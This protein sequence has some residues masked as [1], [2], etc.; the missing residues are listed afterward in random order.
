VS[1]VQPL[2]RLGLL[3][4]VHAE[5]EA[6]KVAIGGLEERGVDALLCAGDIADGMGDIN[7]ACT[8]LEEH[9]V[10]CVAGNHDRW[11]LSDELRDE[12]CATSMKRVLPRARHYLDSLPTTRKLVTP[13][14]ALLLCHGIGDDDLACVKPDHLRHD[15]ERNDAL[16]RVLQGP[17]YDF[18]VNGHTHRAMLRRVRHLTIINAGTLHRNDERR[19][20]LLDLEAR[21]VTFFE[22][23]PGGLVEIESIPLPEVDEWSRV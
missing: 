2:V 17:R 13:H 7:R 12:P 5:D 15:L 1:G 6:L 16:R 20:C 19:A 10:L 14:G 11:L 9:R 21:A 23:R 22:V 8:L 4:D 18:M 3:G